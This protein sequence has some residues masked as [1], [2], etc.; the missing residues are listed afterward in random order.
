[1]QYQQDERAIWLRGTIWLAAYSEPLA[2][3]TEKFVLRWAQDS[4]QFTDIRIHL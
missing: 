3:A 4:D 1:M 2:D